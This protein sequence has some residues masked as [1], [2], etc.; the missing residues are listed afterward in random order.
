MNFSAP[1]LTQEDITLLSKSATEARGDVLKMTTIAGCGHPGGSMSS[2]EM[3]TLLWNCAN[4]DPQKPTMKNRDRI[5][6]S[7]GHTSPGVYAVLGRCGFY[8]VNEAVAH[9]RQT[10]SAFAGHVEQCVPGVEWDTGNLGQGLSASVGFALARDIQG[11]DYR[12]FCLMGDGEQQKGQ[13]AEARRVA[14]KFKLKNIVAFVDLNHLQINGATDGVMPQQIHENWVSDGWRAITVDGHDYNALYHAIRQALACDEPAVIIAQTIMGKGVSFME[15]DAKWHGQALSEE[16]CRD[17]LK[18]LGLDD[19][20]DACIARR[21]EPQTMRMADFK[22]RDVPVNLSHG[23]PRTYGSE[24]K[25]D[26]RSAWGNAIYDIV[27]E[28]SNNPESTP[29]AILDCDLMPSVKTG[30]VARE[31]PHNFIQC[32]I[33][34]H[35]TAAI[36]GAMSVSG[37]QAFFADF[38]VFGVDETYNQHRLSTLNH[39]HP[40]IVCTHCG[41]DV[42]E[43]GKTHQCVDYVGAFRNF[44]SFEIF[45]PADPNQTD[46]A[47]RY[48]AV[49]D[50]P[51]LTI[52]GRSKMTPVLT[53]DGTP[54]FGENYSF[55]YGKADIVRSGDDAAII[56]MGALCA[57]A[58]K[59][60]D[61]LKEQGINA[62]V[63]HIAT[64]VAPDVEALVDAAK[65]GTVVTVEDHLVSSGLGTIVAETLFAEGVTCSFQK[66]GV[67]EYGS[68]GK[69]NELFEFYNLHPEG[70]AD[71]VKKLR[72]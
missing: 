64:P 14:A 42:G 37:V 56:V 59:A 72:A 40:K 44:L 8:D 46:R 55:E 15:N 60:H 41:L 67:T 38:G 58:V 27:K 32:G 23:T 30:A 45:V 66:L 35:N 28:N 36:A 3:Y 12:V 61:I 13:I 33:Q 4:V 50:R 1:E 19:D 22:G 53:E 65:T 16:Q 9:F 2:M 26:N 48:M 71:T 21:S 70:I 10:G 11:L 6:V 5:V 31:F 43:D 47:V 25:T 52:M 18:E 51:S 39:A 57:H 54:F 7:H 63:I 62:R 24:D 20:L 17:A 49:N 68:S 29:I 34:E 69:P